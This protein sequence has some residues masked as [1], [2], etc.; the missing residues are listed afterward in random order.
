MQ[1]RY[2]AEGKPTD[3]ATTEEEPVGTQLFDYIDHDKFQRPGPVEAANADDRSKIFIMEERAAEEVQ[4]GPLSCVLPHSSLALVL[5]VLPSSCAP[6]PLVLPTSLPPSFLPSSSPPSPLQDFTPVRPWQRSVVAPGRPPPERLD[7]PVDGLR[8]E[9]V[10]GF[11][12]QDVRGGV[13]YTHTGEVMFFAGATNVVL[14][15][16]ARAQRFH[17]EHTDEVTCLA[18]HPTRTLVAT[19]QQGAVPAI[20]I[21]DYEASPD[22]GGMPTVRS[23]TG[24]HRRA[25]TQMAF[26]GGSGRWGSGRQRGCGGKPLGRLIMTPPQTSPPPPS[27]SPMH[28]QSRASTS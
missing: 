23:I 3:E 18:K 6:F 26:D 19:G 1:W 15:T 25:V 27:H 13:D 7:E 9:W 22:G 24:V 14:D 16:R 12:A 28:R 4:R 21:W 17:C 10:Y 8:L 5:P 11:R 2:R 20:L